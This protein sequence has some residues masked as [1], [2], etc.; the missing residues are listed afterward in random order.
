MITIVFL[1]NGDRHEKEIADWAL[2]HF[3]DAMVRQD[4]FKYIARI[5]FP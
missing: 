5:I 1:Q 2:E 3:I 4:Y